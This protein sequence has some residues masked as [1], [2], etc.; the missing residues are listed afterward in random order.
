MRAPLVLAAVMVVLLGLAAA[1]VIRMPRGG[2]AG[3]APELP[4]SRGR[5][6]SR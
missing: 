4:P 1:L 6:T 2:P 3:G 5:I